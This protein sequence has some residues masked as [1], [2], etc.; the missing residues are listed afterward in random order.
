LFISTRVR[1][2]QYR[3]TIC[4]ETIDGLRALIDQRAAAYK[5]VSPGGASGLLVRT[6]RAIGRGKNATRIEEYKFD[7]AVVTEICKC[8]KQAA[9]ESGDWRRAPHSI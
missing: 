7:R 8:L 6:V 2:R 9:I 4:Q 5:D 1:G 3:V